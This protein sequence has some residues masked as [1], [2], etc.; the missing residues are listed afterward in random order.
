M[1]DLELQDDT[2]LNTA[3]SNGTHPENEDWD[4]GRLQRWYLSISDDDPPPREVVENPPEGLGPL[5]PEDLL[6]EW[7]GRTNGDHSNGDSP[8]DLPDATDN[9]YRA[10]RQLGEAGLLQDAGEPADPWSEPNR[11]IDTSQWNRGRPDSVVPGGELGDADSDRIALEWRKAAFQP[12]NNL[13]DR[14]RLIVCLL[15]EFMKPCGSS[16]FPGMKKLTARVSMAKN[17]LKD[18]LRSL[19]DKGWVAWLEC[20]RASGADSSR[21]YVP[22]VPE[23][24]DLTSEEPDS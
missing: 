13:D 16:C 8:G 24:S 4:A 14:E 18:R 11:V 3:E 15:A 6:E 21:L 5:E 22:G 19:Q 23:D 7:E 9:A 2:E 10:R 1:R 12:D 20:Q 17:T